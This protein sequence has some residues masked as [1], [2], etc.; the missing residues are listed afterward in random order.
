MI[1]PRTMMM[2][3]E[4]GLAIEARVLALYHACHWIARLGR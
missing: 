3:F 2:N 1:A 4:E